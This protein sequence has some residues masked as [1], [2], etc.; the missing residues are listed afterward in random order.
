MIYIV[1]FF[2]FL[3]SFGG[4]SSPAHLSFSW[5]ASVGSDVGMCTMLHQ[6]F[7]I[8]TRIVSQSIKEDY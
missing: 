7:L 6:A 2:T 8:D 1:F 3:F 5:V 4:E